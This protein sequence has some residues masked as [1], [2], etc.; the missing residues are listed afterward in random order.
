LQQ[1][2]AEALGFGVNTKRVQKAYT[3]L[4]ETCGA[5]LGILLHTPTADIA[6]A[7]PEN[8]QRVAEGVSKVRAGDIYIEPGFD[9][10]FGKVQVWPDEAAKLKTQ[11]PSQSRMAL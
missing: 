2:V 1:V 8:G 6:D 11:R 4:I 10:Q 5:E 3:Q 7:L 9:G